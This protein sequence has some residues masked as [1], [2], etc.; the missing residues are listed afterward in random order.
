MTP[1]ITRRT[2]IAGACALALAA[3]A[4]PMQAQAKERLSLS[5]WGSPKHPQVTHFVDTFMKAVEEKSGG[6]VSFRY[7]GGGEMV[8]QKF[9]PT[10]VPQGTVDISLTTLDTWS[11]RIPE[12]SVTTGPLW[13][14]TM[15]QART[16]LLPG[17]P[18]FQ[19]FD[20]K[21]RENGAVLL[22]M[23]DIGSP[24][25]TTKFEVQNPDDLKGRSVRVYSK[26]AAEIMQSLGAS[27]VTM[28]VGEVY[29]GLQRGTVE[30]AMGGLQGA[31]GLK[32]YEVA[33][34]MFAPNGVIGTLV[35]GYVMNKQKF[36][37]LSPELQKILMD[38]ATEARNN[39]MDYM[40][41]SYDEYLEKVRGFGLTVSKLDPGSAEWDVW[42]KAMAPLKN[43]DR[44]RF[45]A[46]LVGLLEKQ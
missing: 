38:S 36:E 8:K 29:S 42:S 12:V 19:Y 37:S 25:L 28:S 21:L 1:R 39:A 17:T 5:T 34:Y 22:A 45:S 27:P 33:S 43:R 2:A 32:H 31:V 6:E 18:L 30:G 20:G 11:G 4:S 44:E 16:A 35:H 10:A 3:V 9:V 46:D 7:F 24:V 15:K 13:P 26:G 23:F 14:V 40:I 41:Q